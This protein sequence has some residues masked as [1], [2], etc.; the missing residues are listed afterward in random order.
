MPPLGVAAPACLTAATHPVAWIAPTQLD[1]VRFRNLLAAIVIEFLVLHASALY[2]FGIAR[3]EDRLARRAWILGGLT[4]LY[5]IPITPLAVQL[6]T[7][8]PILSFLW[9]LPIRCS[10]ILT[11]PGPPTAG[12]PLESAMRNE[13]NKTAPRRLAW[14]HPLMVVTTNDPEGKTEERDAVNNPEDPASGTRKVPFSRE[15]YIERADFME[16]PPPKY[17]RLKPGGE[18]R[19]KYA[20]I[21]K[22][23]E[24]MKDSSGEVIELRCTADLESKSG[25]ATSNRKIKGTIH[26]VSAQDAVDAEVRLYDRLFIVPEPDADGDFKSFINPH[27]LE[28]VTAKCEPSLGEARPDLRYQ[29]ERLAYFA[30]DPD[31][32]QGKRVFNSKITLR[33]TWANEAEKK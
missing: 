13:F 30:L 27:S 19:L 25:G 17:F 23:E 9:L 24:V 8:C 5:L 29:F 15:V 31:S 22:C 7:H 18:V 14:L 2:G 6:K 1:P 11:P 33:A 20:Y 3:R 12:A 4:I 32:R 21:I 10:F 26:W 28:V 16:T